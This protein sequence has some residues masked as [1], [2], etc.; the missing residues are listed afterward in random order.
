MYLAYWILTLKPIYNQYYT[1]G[2]FMEINQVFCDNTL[3]YTPSAEDRA[4]ILMNN[5]M[6]LVPTRRYSWATGI[7][8]ILSPLLSFTDNILGFISRQI[9]KRKIPTAG[10]E[11][12]VVNNDMVKLHFTDRRRVIQERVL[13]DS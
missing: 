9:I 1:Y 3:Q 4:N 2:R 5:R 6:F 10:A 8:N 13:Q 7:G 11:G 12:I